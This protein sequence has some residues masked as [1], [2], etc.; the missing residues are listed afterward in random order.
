[1]KKYIYFNLF[2]N[3]L[4]LNYLLSGYQY[5]ANF[6]F[7]LALFILL[8]SLDKKNILKIVLFGSLVFGVCVLY[9]YISGLAFSKYNY[10]VL[11]LSV[12]FSS[13]IIFENMIGLNFEIFKQFEI[14]F[15]KLSFIFLLFVSISILFPDYAFRLEYYP[16]G[17][18]SLIAM[19]MISFCPYILS[20]QILSFLKRIKR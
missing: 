1:M 7:V 20:I 14:L 3:G 6:L 4:G 9:S 8:I 17:K 13:I 2:I 19:L 12:S 11:I 16:N 15:L 10:L 5:F 18:I